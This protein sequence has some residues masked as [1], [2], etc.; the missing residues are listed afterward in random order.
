M[1]EYYL[2]LVMDEPMQDNYFSNKH[3]VDG[4]DLIYLDNYTTS[5]KSVQELGNAIIHEDNQVKIS[6]A[7]IISGKEYERIMK[8][9]QS[10]PQKVEKVLLSEYKNLLY[11]LFESGENPDKYIEG[12]IN[13]YKD[14]LWKHKKEIAKSLVRFVKIPEITIDENISYEDLVQVFNIY[15]YNY[16]DGPNYKKIRDTYIELYRLKN[17]K[18]S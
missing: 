6:N 9:E 16:Q 8:G 12:L 15:Y 4:G 18:E 2:F 1:Q 10:E 7:I 3:Q 11:E 13:E 14:Y 17:N 5:F